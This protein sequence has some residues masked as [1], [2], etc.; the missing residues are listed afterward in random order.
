MNTNAGSGSKGVSG[1]A[2][3]RQSIAFSFKKFVR[4]GKEKIER[5]LVVRSKVDGRFP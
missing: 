3:W 5:Y 4:K 1:W 2:K